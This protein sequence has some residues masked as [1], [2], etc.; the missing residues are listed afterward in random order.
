MEIVATFVPAPR[1][2]PAEE[3]QRPPQGATTAELRADLLGTDRDLAPLVS[4]SPLPVVV[5]LR[6]RAEGG[7]GPDE[8][9]ERRRFFQK[10]AAL[11]AALFDLEAARDHDFIDAVIPRD[12]VILSAHLASGVSPDLE[13]RSVAMLAAGTRFIK[14]V[15]T[16]TTLSDVVAVVRLAQVLD[17]GSRPARRAV[18]FA[19]GDAGRAT[20]LLGP[21]L[22]APFAYAAWDAARAAA[23]GQYLPEEILALIGHLGGRPRRLFAVLRSQGGASL[24][25][26]MHA[27]AYRAC[28]LPNLFV[29]LEIA[30]PAE[31]DAL[32][33]P[34]GESC[35]D[36]LGFSVG[37][38]AVTM[39]WK[40]EAAKRCSVLA[41]RARRAEAVNTVLPRP[42]KVLGD[43][44][45]IDGITRVLAE[46]RVELP[47]S[48][49]LVLGAGGAARAAVV[50]LQLAGAQVAIA[51]RDAA[52]AREAASRLGA[53]VAEPGAGERCSVVVNATPAG[54]DG[55]PS[56]LLEAL[57][58]PSG[59][60]M[61]DLPYGAGPTFLEQLSGERGWR[62]VGGREV[63]LFQAV[64]QFAAMTGVAPP[65]RA[66]AAA[67]GLDAVQE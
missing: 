23:P 61:V 11:P 39:P 43:C 55:E 49:A 9:V 16:A 21:L 38:F 66:M 25:P 53:A 24:S 58:L 6:S 57:R 27:A 18:V 33:R 14:V 5:T 35:L 8:A 45:D 50:A 47:G 40:G 22:G 1:L 44:T 63:L 10:A 20:R 4:A 41:P 7:E 30:E 67:L 64:S 12:R 59:G 31:L 37:G 56:P 62:F 60:V 34:L 15:P 2:D 52:R 54:R 51:A 65:V 36:D 48:R 42:G 13:R 17:K 26:R 19:T 3:L 46:E 29:P 28:G 32:L